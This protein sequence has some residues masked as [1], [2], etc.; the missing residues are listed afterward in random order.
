[1]GDGEGGGGP[2]GEIPFEFDPNMFPAEF[3]DIPLDIAPLDPGTT[4]QTTDTDGG[5]SVPWT[6]FWTLA[7]VAAVAGLGVVTT[8]VAWNWGLRGLDG[9]PRLWAKTQRL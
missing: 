8:R 7:G 9:T 6:L 4:P 5:F 3:F 1:G 2:V